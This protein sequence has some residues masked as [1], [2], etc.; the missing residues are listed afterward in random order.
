[1]NKTREQK[2]ASL[3]SKMRWKKIPDADERSKMMR[4]VRAARSNA[5]GGRGGGRP[6]MEKRC[7]CGLKSW[8]TGKIRNFDCCKRAGKYPL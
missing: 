2:A 1:M 6:R 8:T 7:Y 5:P 3:L 4:K